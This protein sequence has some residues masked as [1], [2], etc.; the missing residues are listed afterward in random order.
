MV[1]AEGRIVVLVKVG[2]REIV[3]ITSDEP[4]AQASVEGSQF[5]ISPPV[6][7][8]VLPRR[9]TEIRADLVIAQPKRPRL[10]CSIGATC[11]CPLRPILISHLTD[12]RSGLASSLASSGFVRPMGKLAPIRFSLRRGR[13]R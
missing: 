3:N 12:G 10:A 7:E 8:L 11:Q 2:T 5:I 9:T 13:L 6:I 1:I 4:L